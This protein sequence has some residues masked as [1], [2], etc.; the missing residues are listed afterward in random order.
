[1]IR[2]QARERREYLYRKALQLQESSL[3]EKRQQLKAALASGKSLSKELAEDEKLQRDFIYDESEQIEI[4]DEYSRLSG[5]SDPKVVITTS[6]DPSVKLLQFSKEIKLMFPNSLKL[7]RGNYIISDLVSTCN[8]VQVSDMILL[9]EHRGVPSSLTVSHFPHGPTAIFTLHNVKLRHDLPNLGNVSESYPHLIFENFQ[10]DLGK[11]VVKI[12]QHL[13]PPGVKKD[14]SRVI[15]FV[16]N[17]DY[18]SVRHHVYVKTKDSVE[19][20]EIGP[21]FEMR[22]YEIRLGLPDNKDAD[23]EWQMRRF[24]RTANRKNYL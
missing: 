10:S 23:V 20:S 3:T 8:R 6:R 24:I 13:F 11:R 19:L 12:L 22:L 17:D 5:I 16:N 9:H 14:S 4:D 7:N 15:T 1:M 18:I 21:R 2:K